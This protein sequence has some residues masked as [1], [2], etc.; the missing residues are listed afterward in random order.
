[1]SCELESLK[2]LNSDQVLASK[3]FDYMIDADPEV[4]NVLKEASVLAD[5]TD[6]TPAEN[7]RYLKIKKA[8]KKIMQPKGST[9]IE[10]EVQTEIYEDMKKN[11]KEL[12]KKL[13]GEGK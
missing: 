5:K 12:E 8:L 1:M 11:I 2:G 6:R 4:E 13:F 7:K 3:A 10:R 9:M